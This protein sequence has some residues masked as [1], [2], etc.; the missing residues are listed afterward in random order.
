MDD[1]T[2]EV[3]RI[4]IEAQDRASETLKQFG[5]HVDGAADHVSKAR[6]AFG[7]LG[8]IGRAHV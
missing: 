1:V 4:I 2:T 8:Q 3:L 5:N 6:I 7:A